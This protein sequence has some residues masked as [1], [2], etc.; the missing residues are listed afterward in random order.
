MPGQEVGFLVAFSAGL[1]SFLSP[2]VLPL[3]PSYLSFVTGLSLADLTGSSL[4]GKTRRLVFLHALLFVL[5]FSL[6]F[7]LMGASV[8][9]LGQALKTN[10]GLITKVGGAII[11]LFGLYLAGLLPL[12]FLSREK[13]FHLHRKPLGFIGSA[14]VGVTFAAGWSPCIGPILGSILIYASTTSPVEGGISLLSAYSLGLALPFLAASLAVSRFISLFGRFK[15][16]LR[17]VSVASGL[18]LVFVGLLVITNYLALLSGYLTSWLL[19]IF[20]FLAP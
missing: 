5:G 9:A 7:I 4:S 11:I 12:K 8:T 20:P 1:I 15:G 18:F 16:Y 13:M 14:A 10:Q 17:V 19:P 3:I 6:V 2:C